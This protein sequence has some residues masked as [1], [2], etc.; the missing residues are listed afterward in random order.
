MYCWPFGAEKDLEGDGNPAKEAAAYGEYMAKAAAAAAAAA[1]IS[2]G[3]QSPPPT[4]IS[5]A[6]AAE[7]CRC[8]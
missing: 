2:A 7:S 1:P 8:E 6:F 4:C 3:R 5:A